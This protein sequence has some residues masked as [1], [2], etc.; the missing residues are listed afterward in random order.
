MKISTLID[1]ALREI[2][3]ISATDEASPQDHAFALRKLNRIIGLYNTQHL[4]NA[5]IQDIKFVQPTAG[6]TPQIYIG[7]GQQFPAVAPTHIEGAF[8]RQSG[9]DYSMNA[10]TSDQWREISYKETVGIPTRYYEQNMGENTS[11][12]YFDCIPIDGLELHLLCKLPINGGVD[13]NTTDDVI[14]EYG[15]EKLLIDR[16]AFELCGAYE[17]GAGEINLLAGKIEE[18][19]TSI[20]AYNYE[21][22]V[23]K[24]SMTLSGRKRVKNRARY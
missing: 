7:P 16:L 11:K 4:L 1:D 9:V 12:I 18:A 20:K 14:F 21:P 5:F 3:V 8:F 2:N 10:M 24:N 19:V 13:F 6:W 23:L 22:S 17:I 15:M